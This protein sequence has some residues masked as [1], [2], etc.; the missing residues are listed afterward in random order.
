MLI[1]SATGLSRFE[2]TSVSVT[3]GSPSPSTPSA[4]MLTHLD[5][6]RDSATQI[7]QSS[8]LLCRPPK[9][10][11][12][13]VPAWE[14]LA[15]KDNPLKCLSHKLAPCYIGPC[16]IEAIISPA[17][18]TVSCSTFQSSVPT[19]C[20]TTLFTETCKS[21][22]CFCFVFALGVTPTYWPPGPFDNIAGTEKAVCLCCLE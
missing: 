18:V 15:A 10:T 1:S 11:C 12:S 2:A 7:D 14:W 20:Q 8:V 5:L 4:M 21:Y 17:A 19:T 22:R 3:Q 13:Q 9:D 16:K 6:G